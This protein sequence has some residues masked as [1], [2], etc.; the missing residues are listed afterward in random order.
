M[1]EMHFFADLD[2]SFSEI[3]MTKIGKFIFAPNDS[4][5]IKTHF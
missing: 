2:E 4:K 5:W 3:C 1:R